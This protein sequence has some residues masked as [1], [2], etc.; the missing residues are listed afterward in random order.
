MNE[1]EKIAL[2]SVTLNLVTI[3]LSLTFSGV[4]LYLSTQNTNNINDR[5]YVQMAI[6]ILSQPKNSDSTDES[7]LRAWAVKVLDEKSPIPFG[8]DLSQGFLFGNVVFPT[9][10]SLHKISDD[11]LHI[12]FNRYF[13]KSTNT[14]DNQ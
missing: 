12:F 13:A 1:N 10:T 9:S 2:N 8:Y 11:E 3:I 5:E 14:R 6:S 7:D 4:S